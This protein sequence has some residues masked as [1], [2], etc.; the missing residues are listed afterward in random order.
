MRKLFLL[1]IL[2]FLA[3]FTFAQTTDGTP[4]QEP[5]KQAAPSIPADKV[6]ALAKPFVGTFNGLNCYTDAVY[7]LRFTITQTGTD[8]P[9]ATLVQEVEPDGKLLDNLKNVFKTADFLVRQDR[10]GKD[11]TFLYVTNGTVMA[12]VTPLGDGKLIG[13]AATEESPDGTPLALA[14]AGTT[15]LVDFVKTNSIICTDEAARRKFFGLPA[16]DAPQIQNNDFNSNNPPRLKTIAFQTSDEPK[17]FVAADKSFQVN[18]PATPT[19]EE[20]KGTTVYGKPYTLQSFS[21]SQNRRLYLVMVSK[22]DFPVTIKDLE[23]AEAATVKDK[24]VKD[25]ASGTNPSGDNYRVFIVDSKEY[26]AGY[27]I[28]AHGNALYQIALGVDQEVADT[29]DGSEV[30]AFLNSFKLL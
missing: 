9:V 1:P 6:A 10:E 14:P 22:Y 5:A 28:L 21:L 3:T 30:A 23:R 24:E 4:S 13:L 15:T 25:V 16:A 27:L 7:G 8:A 19:V 12:A 29:I 26:R 20:G 17:P 18:F 2:L 11:H